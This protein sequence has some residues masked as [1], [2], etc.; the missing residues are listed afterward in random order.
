[1]AKAEMICRNCGTVGE[2]G[3]VTP[4]SFAL[5]V[6]LWLCFL[7]P[8]ILYSIWRIVMRKKVCRGCGSPDLVPIDSPIGK[9]LHKEM[10]Q[11]D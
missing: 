10:A 6:V 1:M 5:E 8:G 9:K 11:V 4:G 2:P 7:L 3:S